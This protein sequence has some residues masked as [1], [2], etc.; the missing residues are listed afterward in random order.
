[1]IYS[2]SDDNAFTIEYKAKTDKPTVINL[3]NHSY[4]NLSGAQNSP[5]GVMN[6]IV[7]LN[8]DR[9]LQ[10][11]K[12]S[13]PTGEIKSV[14]GTPFDFRQPKAIVK[15]IRQNNQQLAFGYGYDQ[16]WIINS[17]Q[18]KL[19]RAAFVFDPQSKRTL[20]I[21]TTEPSI[22][23]YTANHLLG[24]IAGANGVLYRQ[25]DAVAL[26]T[27]HYPDSPNQAH[28]PSTRLDPHQSFQSKT[29]FKFG[30]K[31]KLLSWHPLLLK[32]IKGAQRIKSY[33]VLGKKNAA[34]P[35]SGINE[36]SLNTHSIPFISAKYP[37]PAAAIPLTPNIKPN[38]KPEIMPTRPGT[39][40]CA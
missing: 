24:Q 11:D 38:I 19:Q 27:Q 32:T 2:L 25:G 30:L 3:T 26:E 34:S 13:L 21:L 14:A 1:M 4:F 18:D 16:T 12:N 35:N 33:L 22:Q 5:Y 8:A 36:H 15:D 39:A 31:I 29:V 6:H 17:G 7:Q 9:I 37:S 20:E 23:M 28:F 40:S 10:T